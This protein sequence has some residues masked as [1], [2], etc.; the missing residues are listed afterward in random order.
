MHSREKSGQEEKVLDFL[1]QAAKAYQPHGE[2]RDIVLEI[3]CTDMGKSYQ[4]VLGKETCQVRTEGFLGSTARAEATYSLLRELLLGQKSPAV[5]LLTGR[6]KISGEARLLKRLEDFF[7][8][9]A[10][11]EG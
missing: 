11:G 8:G 2:D 3:A 4:L 7:P 1:H 10:L 9:L 5:A 6:L